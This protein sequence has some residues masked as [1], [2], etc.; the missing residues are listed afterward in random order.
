MSKECEG[1]TT[2]LI[3][4]DEGNTAFAFLLTWLDSA[5]VLSVEFRLM[6]DVRL[7]EIRHVQQRFTIC[8][9]I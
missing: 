1:C 7:W 6:E 4:G 2:I 9:S 5:F 3:G 8:R